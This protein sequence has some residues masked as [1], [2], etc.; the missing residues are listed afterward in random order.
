MRVTASMERRMKKALHEF[1]RKALRELEIASTEDDAFYALPRAAFA[2]FNTGS[3]REAEAHATRLLEMAEDFKDDWN[4]GN[5]LHAGHTVLGLVALERGN[6]EAACASLAASART[7][8]SPQLGSF[9]P[10]MQLAKALLKVGESIVVLNYLAQCKAFWHSGAAWL[11][12]WE[13]K[14]KRGVAP[15]F[16]MHSYG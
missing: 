14:V 8:G 10:T 2:A 11:S 3:P 15:N 1:S 7:P 5:A 16:F 13:G 9:G 12:I 4:Y 6:K